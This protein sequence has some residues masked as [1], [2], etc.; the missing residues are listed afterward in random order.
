MTRLLPRVEL[1][2]L[3]EHEGHE[4]RLTGTRNR[5]LADFPTLLSAVHFSRVLW[6]SRRL[7]PVGIS[8]RVQWR[9]V[10]FSIA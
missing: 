1:N 2:L 3:I 6:P 10:S 9:W 8:M 5:F 7:L 4:F